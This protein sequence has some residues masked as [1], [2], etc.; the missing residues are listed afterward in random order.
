MNFS[1][2]YR[3]ESTVSDGASLKRYLSQGT[4]AASTPEE[5]EELRLPCS[6]RPNHIDL[7]TPTD[8]S[9]TPFKIKPIFE[10]ESP[11]ELALVDCSF[12]YN[13]RL[14]S[15]TLEMA[16]LA[17]PGE[18]V[19]SSPGVTPRSDEVNLLSAALI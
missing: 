18:L 7:P 17:L 10:S 9:S 16:V 1:G 14:L 12:R 19:Q 15:R 2:I 4:V 11:D 13:C 8:G 6:D 5:Q 3:D